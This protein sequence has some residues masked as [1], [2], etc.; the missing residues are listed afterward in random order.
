MRAQA[1]A[2]SIVVHSVVSLH[3]NMVLALANY[4]PP[5]FA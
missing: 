5:G 3:A 4:Y 2:W 1:Q